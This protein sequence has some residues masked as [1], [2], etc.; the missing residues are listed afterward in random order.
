MRRRLAMRPM[1]LLVG[2]CVAAAKMAK[3]AK[4]P[5]PMLNSF[6]ES[7]LKWWCETMENEADKRCN[8]LFT[9]RHIR[10]TND[11]TQIRGLSQQL[12]AF[13]PKSALEQ[14]EQYKA[15]TEEFCQTAEKPRSCTD[16]EVYMTPILKGTKAFPASE[17][18]HT[19]Q[20]VAGHTRRRGAEAVPLAHGISAPS[21]TLES[22]GGHVRRN[23]TARMTGL[24][25]G[26][27]PAGPIAA[28]VQG[29][30]AA[31]AHVPQLGSAA[32]HAASTQH[33]VGARLPDMTAAGHGGSAS[34]A[35]PHAV[36]HA[37]PH[38][39]PHAVHNFTAGQH[40][41]PQLNLDP[42]MLA[43][44]HAASKQ[45]HVGARPPDITAAGNGGS[46]SHSTT[47]AHLPSVAAHKTASG[48]AHAPL[49]SAGHLAGFAKLPTAI[50]AAAHSGVLGGDAPML[51]AAKASDLPPHTKGLPPLRAR[52]A[53]E[54]PDRATHLSHVARSNP[55]VPSTARHIDHLSAVVARAT[56]SAS[57]AAHWA[58][59]GIGGSQPRPDDR[60]TMH[61]AIVNACVLGKNTASRAVC[62]ALPGVVAEYCAT[63][64][65]LETHTACLAE[66]RRL[67]AILASAAHPTES[68]EV[69]HPAVLGA[70][71]LLLLVG[72][73]ALANRKKVQVLGCCMQ[74]PF[75]YALFSH[76]NRPRRTGDELDAKDGV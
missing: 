11:G 50:T 34:H 17:P 36:R 61:D 51:T 63:L 28:A 41:M 70:I 4:E 65:G 49:V 9:H 52:G 1:L 56:S 12:R 20:E 74:L 35:V 45:H 54:L 23:M 66:Q 33:H 69:P 58:K 18:D 2:A 46:A 31:P 57:T 42:E 73:W 47:A 19:S 25:L 71:V 6:F 32:A 13:L 39:V 40:I 21:A 38:A 68:A 15:L 14:R 24:A 27:L 60:A 26:P 44:A 75:V 55:G 30:I 29:G 16:K 7:L 48:G 5:P 64:S 37:V 72:L 53:Q 43:R 10:Q 67:Q 76:K 3:E 22:A 62:A 59:P 8:L